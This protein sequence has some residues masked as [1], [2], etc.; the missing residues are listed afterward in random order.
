MNDKKEYVKATSDIFIKYL[1]GMDTEKSN[2]T[3]VLWT[4]VLV[5]AVI[6]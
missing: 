6:T 5:F 2:L 4:S 1:F 3:R